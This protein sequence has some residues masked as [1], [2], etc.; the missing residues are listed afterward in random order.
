LAIIRQPSLAAGKIAK[1]GVPNETDHRLILEN[2]PSF[3]SSCDGAGNR[4]ENNDLPVLRLTKLQNDQ[5]CTLPAND[6]PA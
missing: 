1:D 5:V 3:V 4:N 2:K 6:E